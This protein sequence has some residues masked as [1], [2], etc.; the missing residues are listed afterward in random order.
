MLRHQIQHHGNKL[1]KLKKEAITINEKCKKT[2]KR[3]GIILPESQHKIQC[4]ICERE[5]YGQSRATVMKH[6]EHEHDEVS[7]SVRLENRYF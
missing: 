4:K 7:K 3:L 5:F 6:V 2:Y 1:Q